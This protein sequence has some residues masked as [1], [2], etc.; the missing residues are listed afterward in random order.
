VHL[1][2]PP[3]SRWRRDPMEL[4]RGVRRAEAAR[5]VRSWAVVPRGAH[6]HTRT[7]CAECPSRGDP[8]AIGGTRGH[9]RRC[10]RS[11]IMRVRRTRA[12]MS[13]CR[14]RRG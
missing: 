13:G 6:R 14:R 1:H 10:I 12:V 7:A 4:W 11:Q 3:G 8:V 9:R 5:G 2:L